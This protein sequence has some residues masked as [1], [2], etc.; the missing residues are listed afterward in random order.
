MDFCGRCDQSAARDPDGAHLRFFWAQSPGYL[1]GE[2]RYPTVPFI[3]AFAAVNAFSE[4]LHF[5]A[6]LLTRL[7]S[8][9]GKG[10]ALWLTSI[11]FGLA[12]W[13]GHP[14]RPTGVILDRKN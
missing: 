1:P 2:G 4:E 3:F 10:K 5:R 7:I 12:H 13:F 6:V 11:L 14:S 8:P 9:L